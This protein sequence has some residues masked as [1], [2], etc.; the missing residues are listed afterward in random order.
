MKS[1][2]AFIIAYVSL[3]TAYS[4]TAEDWFDKGNVKL[5]LQD[6]KGAIADFTKAIEL[7][8]SY[9]KEAYYN[10][11]LSKA[12]L[13][14]NRGAIADFTKAIE[15]DP[16]YASAYVNRGLSKLMLNQK[17]SGCL[18]LSKAGEL[19]HSEAYEVIRQLCN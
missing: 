1:L 17:D 2:F 10:R 19:G 14:D 11:G 16:N 12:R 8:P 3:T 18:D 13:Q 7:D 9:V 6:Y 5:R 15:F 4:Q